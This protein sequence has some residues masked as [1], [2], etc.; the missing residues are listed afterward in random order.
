M[1]GNVY[2]S[3]DLFKE[4]TYVFSCLPWP[5]RDKGEAK[6][7]LPRKSVTENVL[8]WEWREGKAKVRIKGRVGRKF[9]TGNGVK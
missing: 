3:T 7:C 6:E 8:T 5:Y 2:P 1:E 4:Q 9:L